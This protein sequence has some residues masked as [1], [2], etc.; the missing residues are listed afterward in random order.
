[1]SKAKQTVL[2][3]IPEGMDE[4]VA[5]INESTNEF[6]AYLPNHDLDYIQSN[7]FTKHT[8]YELGMLQDMKARF[9][10]GVFLDVGANI[11]NHSLYMLANTNADVVAFE[12]NDKLA[13]ALHISLMLNNF[14]ERAEI[15]AHGL[16][17]VECY[18]KFKD[19]L[20]ENLGAQEI[21]TGSGEILIKTLDSLEFSNN[22]S[23]IKMDV[24][25]M[26]ISVLKGSAEI[27][28]HNRPKLYIEAQKLEDFKE[29]SSFLSGLG[30]V[31]WKTFNATPTHLFLPG[32]SLSVERRLANLQA[33]AVEGKYINDAEVT[34]LRSEL[35]NANDK[36]R[37]T[38]ERLAQVKEA[39]ANNNFKL[40]DVI[41]Q[42][43]YENKSLNQ[44]LDSVNE[45][46]RLAQ[47]QIALS[48]AL[49]DTFSEQILDLKKIL[50]AEK[51]KSRVLKENE[52]HLTQNL[53]DLDA[54]LSSVK[55]DLRISNDKYRLNLQETIPNLRN[56]IQSEADSASKLSIENQQLKKSLHRVRGSLSYRLSADLA[57]VIR[58]P[59]KAIYLPKRILGYF[60][61]YR[62]RRR[63][64]KFSESTKIES[65][66]NVVTPSLK[67]SFIKP[68]RTEL[69][70]DHVK[71]SSD[72][73]ELKVASIMDEFTAS[74]FFPECK[75]LQLTPEGWHKELQQSKVDLLFVESAWRGKDDLWGS[76]VGHHSSELCGIIEYCVENKIPT[77]FWNKEDPVHF[78]TFLSTAKL[79]DSVFTT[80]ID[81]VD[82]YKKHLHHENV[83]FLPFA[84]QPRNHNPLEK[85]ERKEC[86]S[87]AGAYYAKYP[88]RTADLENFITKL[89][90]EFPIEIYDRNYLKDDENYKFPAEY[91]RFIVG[92]LPFEQID[93]AYKG[94]KYSI[95]L[96]S[97]KQSQSMFARR[98]FELIA[99][100]TLVISNYS[101]GLRSMFGDLV[102]S[103]DSSEQVLAKLRVHESQDSS[104]DRIRLAAL[105]K[106]MSE[107]TYAQR[108]AFVCEKVGIN[109]FSKPNTRIM[110]L[111]YA[112]NIEELQLI[113]DS[114]TRQNYTEKRLVVMHKID[115]Y[116]N[117]NSQMSFVHID[118]VGDEPLNKFCENGEWLSIISAKDYYGPN[119][120]VDLELARNYSSATTIGKASYYFCKSSS[121]SVDLCNGGS[122]YLPEKNLPIKRSISIID[123]RE[124]FSTKLREF[125]NKIDTLCFIDQASFSV[126]RFNYCEEITN[127]ENTGMV[128]S[129]VNDLKN[130]N[131]GMKFE[132]FTL[133]QNL[134]PQ[135]V[136]DI[137]E[138]DVPVV[139]G[140]ELMAMFGTLSFNK[141]KVNLVNDGV[142]INSRLQDTKHQYLYADSLLEI[143]NLCET[144]EYKCHFKMSPGLHATFVFLFFD[145]SKQ[146]IGHQM[147]APNKND[148]IEIPKDAQFYQTGIRLYGSGEAKIEKLIK[149]HKNLEPEFLISDSET[150]VLT[151]NYPDYDDLYRNGF[152]HSRVKA[153]R[154]QAVETNVFCFQAGHNLSF[155]EFE[156]I[157]VL[158][159]SA[160][161]LEKLL[162]S[163]RCKRVLVH[164][165]DEEMWSVL[166]K[167]IQNLEVFVWVHGSE[168]QPWW[169]R[170]YNYNTEEALESAK[171]KSDE[172]LSFWRK[173]LKKMP[174][175]LHLIFVSQYFA[176]E[177][178]EDL[179]IQLPKNKYEIIHNPIDREIFSYEPKD[180][181]QRLKLL[182]IRPY[183]S[184]KYANDLTVEM[185]MLLSKEGFFNELEFR[186]IGDGVLF[187]ELLGPLRK[188]KNVKI[189]RKFLR[190]QEI[191]ALHKQ[192]GIF[193]CPT[194]MDAQ[195]VSRDEAMSSGL[196]PVTNDVAAIPEFADNTCAI[197]APADDAKSM[198]QGVKELYLSEELFL[199]KS[200]AAAERVALQTDQ[201]LILKKELD[202][203]LLS[204]Q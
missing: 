161:A 122:E 163:G 79:F 125:L 27:I 28:K 99:S 61:L 39:E 181:G 37:Q 9:D 185:I 196:I 198:A 200:H 40:K 162:N 179:E 172:R 114:F 68:K 55:S 83:Y 70:F 174:D 111:S 203:F 69:N 117:S 155:R 5:K 176:D 135:S 81:C 45:K 33:H 90:S 140:E 119:Y 127:T 18:A 141:V 150:L 19:D 109:K 22:I 6:L 7:L 178:M 66:P 192:Y 168:I 108:L 145:S 71:M 62:K 189:E 175:N 137:A 100:N 8:P 10:E 54:E 103:T 143:N 1:M 97:I 169:R 38:E 102:I 118:E 94:Y 149:G 52:K 139:V 166:S 16:G 95:N 49:S 35:A 204:V 15:K 107:H 20:P 110:C 60:R 152:V 58:S 13:E 170:E 182:S 50:E 146:R 77:V 183:A 46:Y 138:A 130:L 113:I 91:E 3:S 158:S 2:A 86:I 132:E 25:G 128:H 201:E 65:R 47:E 17:E 93:Q 190:H 42:K 148:L 156:G 104:G 194:R 88:D 180:P 75:L 48:K 59:L 92:T 96:N 4:C 197:L 184:A 76:K 133:P 112:E 105:R 131:Q 195:G 74:S 41:A 36:Y 87:F 26:E 165:L 106:V 24:E 142:L 160:S 159:G 136:E 173:I 84:C 98:I 134:E 115:D 123:E 30:Y 43:G 129:L 31:Y 56:Q 193:L 191:A 187:D 144:H 124:I 11:G 82:R 29:I 167:H 51:D 147:I 72:S 116:E 157:D 32:E 126:D 23:M 64:L 63:T 44:M 57:K 85:F 153:Y 164:F 14:G 12:P 151:N 121:D 67:A 199:K 188:F 78:Q 21:E 202:L 34:V 80:D 53:C 89:S 154:S 186:L 120:L 177:V 171:I 73:H 101:K